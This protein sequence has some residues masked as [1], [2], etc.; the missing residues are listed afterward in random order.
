MNDQ[1]IFAI[2]EGI[3]ITAQAVALFYLGKILRSLTE[4]IMI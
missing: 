3:R 4:N 1:I 2:I